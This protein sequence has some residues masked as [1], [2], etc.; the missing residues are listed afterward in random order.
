M[1]GELL[2]T[3]LAF[4]ADLDDLRGKSFDEAEELIKGVVCVAD[5]ENRS[6][7][8]PVRG[9]VNQHFNYLDTY[10][11][12]ASARWT[13]NKCEVVCQGMVNCG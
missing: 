13:L 11:G 10:V 9:E 12:L 1:K 2:E 7:R 5:N 8:M 3:F 6:L 4:P